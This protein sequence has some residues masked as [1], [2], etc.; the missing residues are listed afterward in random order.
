MATVEVNIGDEMRGIRET[1]GEIRDLLARVDEREQGTRRL[2]Y[3]AF[4]F[5]AAMFLAVVGGVAQG[6]FA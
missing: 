6:V 4:G 2:V 1:V 3:A 5:S